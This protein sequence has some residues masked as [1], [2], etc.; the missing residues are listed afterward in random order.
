MILLFNSKYKRLLINMIFQQDK[1]I[2]M[3]C[4]KI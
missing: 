1:T 3:Q 2:L 4:L